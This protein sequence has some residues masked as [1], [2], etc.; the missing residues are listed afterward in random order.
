M[1]RFSST[2][3]VFYRTYVS[4]PSNAHKTQIVFCAF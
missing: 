1:P 4:Y 3:A 2:A